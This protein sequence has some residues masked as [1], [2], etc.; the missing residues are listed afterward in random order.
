VVQ[1]LGSI[2]L[3]EYDQP[4]HGGNRDGWIDAK[5]SIYTKLLICVD[6][7]HNGASDPGELMTLQQ[8]GIKAI[9]VHYAPDKWTGI[10]GEQFRFKSVLKFSGG[11]AESIYDVFL[12]AIPNPNNTAKK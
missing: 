9:S 4:A 3:A 1:I 12:K 6:R 8:A 2:I 5:G 11:K 10:Y 7:N